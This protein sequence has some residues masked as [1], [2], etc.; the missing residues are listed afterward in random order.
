MSD[1]D[2]DMGAWASNPVVQGLRD[3]DDKYVELELELQEKLTE[4]ERRYDKRRAPILERRRMRLTEADELAD[5]GREASASSTAKPPSTSVEDSLC[6][7]AATPAVPGFWRTVLQNSTEFAQ[8]IEEYD[9]PLLEYLQ[10]VTVEHVDKTV[11]ATGSFKV[12]FHFAAN[13]FITNTEL[14]KIYHMD[15]PEPYAG[16]LECV[17]VESDMISW[18]AGKNFTV[19]VRPRHQSS[20]RKKKPKQ[21]PKASF[22]RSFFRKLGP[23][24]E[25]PEEELEEEDHEDPEGIMEYLLEEDYERG[26]A[27]RDYIVPHAVRWFTGDACDEFSEDEDSEEDREEGSPE[28]DDKGRIGSEPTLRARTGLRRRIESPTAA[29]DQADERQQQQQRADE[30]GESSASVG[31][32]AGDQ[33]AADATANPWRLVRNCSPA[34]DA[35]GDCRG[36]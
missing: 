2:C 14:V 3:L 27:L 7:A 20:G 36:Q 24:E 21:V 6:K 32:N 34:P 22:F 30:Q 16:R 17:K 12:T 19:L 25:V 18:R 33:E 28:D 13:P 8:D 29:E 23:D 26:R 9:E 15:R 31:S 35:A 1:G 5:V 4:L 11:A 10:D